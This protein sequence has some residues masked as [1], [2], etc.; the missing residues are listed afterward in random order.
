M[1]NLF[2][3]TLGMAGMAGVLLAT[4]TALAQNLTRAQEGRVEAAK[5]WA[6][7]QH[8]YQ[9]DRHAEQ[10]HGQWWLDLFINSDL[11][12]FTDNGDAIVRLGAELA[13]VIEQEVV[14]TMDACYQSC[15]DIERAYGNPGNL[16]KSR[17]RHVYLER[18]NGLRSVGLWNNYN[19]SPVV[20]T[21]AFDRGCNRLLDS[22]SA[23]SPTIG[24][25][26]LRL[27][28]V[29]DLS[30]AVKPEPQTPIQSQPKA[31]FR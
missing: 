23:G 15:T 28:Q 12:Q 14:R 29:A 30:L 1:K 26:A 25:V 7:C 4:E 9:T 2:A 17:F 11:S 5:C 6:Q 24:S 21:P 31:Q 10:A 8:Q 16:A 3:A 27:R 18:R 19:N 13:C 22:A 20:N